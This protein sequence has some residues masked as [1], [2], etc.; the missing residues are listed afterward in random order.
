MPDPEPIRVL[1]VDDEPDFLDVTSRGLSRRGF[2]VSAAEEGTSALALVRERDFDLVILDIRMPGMGGE[3]TFRAIREL[4]PSLPVIILTGHGTVEQAY[5]LSRSGIFEYLTKPCDL[6]KLAKVARRAYDSSHEVRAE[7]DEGVRVL[8]VDDDRDF[9]EALAIA[10]ARRGFDVVVRTNGADAL[11]I[12]A[13][14]RFDV[15]VVDLYMPEMDGLELLKSMKQTQPQVEVLML[16]G[17]PSVRFAIQG[18][19]DGAFDFLVKPPSIDSL[20]A[21]LNRAKAQGRQQSSS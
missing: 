4:V 19:A 3:E 11:E 9:A 18:M 15:A 10:L 1:L 14:E 21:Q 13:D 2:E 17:Q 5:R 7:G 20:V 12:V 16:T 8:V 6:D